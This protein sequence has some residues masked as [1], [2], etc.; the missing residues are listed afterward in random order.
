M[1]NGKTYYEIDPYNRLIAK[2][3]GR[4]SNVKGFRKVLNGRFKTGP[5]NNLYYEVYKPQKGE[6]Q[7]INIS[8][9]YRLDKQHNLIFS[10][11][12]WNDKYTKRG[13]SL[14]AK[15][16]GATGRE[17]LF[18]V[19]TK[20]GKNKRS[21]YAMAL[22]G[23]WQVDKRNRLVFGVKNE[24]GA[25]DNLTFLNAWSI[26]KN[27]EIEYNYGGGR[28]T[29]VLKGKWNIKDKNELKYTITGSKES[30]LKIASSLARLIP[31]SGK[32]YVKFETTIN[33]TCAKNIKRRL[34]FMCRYKP[35]K[36]KEIILEITPSGKKMN[37]RLGALYLES[38]LKDGE[39]YA[40]GGIALKW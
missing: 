8:G 39:K 13:S 25:T 6:P 1:N 27:N 37:I 30:A 21:F 4:K 34:S 33:I 40:G 11:N 35:G 2:R 14:R 19:G 9:K 7:K 32:A 29:V 36:N 26:N 24:D 20:T 28:D 18:T 3:P 16:I 15:L 12:K 5:G 17:L 10:V 38:F 31:L 23:A 22:S